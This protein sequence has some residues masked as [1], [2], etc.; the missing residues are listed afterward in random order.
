M[1]IASQD[2]ARHYTSLFFCISFEL[3]LALDLHFVSSSRK[4]VVS[5]VIF[6]RVEDLN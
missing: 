2:I 5:F 4:D 1:D 6:V 3:L